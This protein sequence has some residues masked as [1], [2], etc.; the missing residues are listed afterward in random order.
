MTKTQHMLYFWNPNDFLIPNM[1]IDTSPWSSCSRQS[2]WLHC[3][4]HKISS[5]APS[6][7]PFRD[8]FVNIFIHLITE[9][10]NY[11]F[12]ILATSSSR[13]KML[14]KVWG[15]AVIV[16]MIYIYCWTREDGGVEETKQGQMPWPSYQGMLWAHVEITHHS[17][18]SLNDW[19][20]LHPF[21]R[22]QKKYPLYCSR[23]ITEW[24]SC[25]RNVSDNHWCPKCQTVLDKTLWYLLQTSS[26]AF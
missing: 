4:S 9:Q 8:F 11:A 10:C 14:I 20:A 25:P 15:V 21:Y 26:K 17:L 18:E 12:A 2:P 22:L 3:S 5:T 24:N 19:S 16:Q 7:S 13:R 6:V 23:C 1:M